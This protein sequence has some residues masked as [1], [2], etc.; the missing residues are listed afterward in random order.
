MGQRRSTHER[1]KGQLAA[2]REAMRAHN[3]DGDQPIQ[4]LLDQVERAALA[5]YLGEKPEPF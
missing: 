2:I 5:E 4:E 1:P 3:I